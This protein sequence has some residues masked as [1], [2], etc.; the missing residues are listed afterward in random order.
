MNKVLQIS[1]FNIFGFEVRFYGI[2]IAIAFL[3]GMFLAI[4]FCKKKGYDENLPY[5][6]ILII[7]P[8]AIIGARFGYVLFHLESYPTFLSM[9][10]IWEGGLMIYSG[11][12]FAVVALG[13]FCYI[14]KINFID[15]LDMLAP[16][17]ILGQA[18]GRWGNFFNQEA[19]GSL[20]TNQNLQWFPFSVWIEKANFTTEAT[21]QVIEFFGETAYQNMSGA[22]FNATFF[23][24]SF[25]CLGGFVLLFL[26]FRKTNTKGL[27]T[28][29]YLTY[30]G[31][32]RFFVE[33][34]RTDS[35][36]LGSLKV[37]VLISGL[38]FVGGLTYLIYI[39][40]KRHKQKNI[41]TRQI[42]KS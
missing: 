33:M 2:L 24:E 37:S 39:L 19:Y 25:W 4:N 1:G 11:I 14:K 21:S 23:Y 34:L 27:C 7:F 31:F 35:L 22:W 38:I 10:K 29:T 5:Q 17:L 36:Y 28:A 13:I 18:I 12:L 42:N 30:Y 15:I 16:I 8:T 32:E 40:T 26:L 20:V 6:L 3:V 41:E 9:L